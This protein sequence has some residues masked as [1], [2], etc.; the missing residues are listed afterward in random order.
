[1]VRKSQER[2]K[3][4]VNML[5]HMEQL[6]TFHKV[7]CPQFDVDVYYR[8]KVIDPKKPPI[9]TLFMELQSGKFRHS[10]KF[11]EPFENMLGEVKDGIKHFTK[12]L[13]SLEKTT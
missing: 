12:Y 2:S 1:M 11:V 5:P 13:E 10:I 8:E 9:I 3:D 6:V 7:H 4:E